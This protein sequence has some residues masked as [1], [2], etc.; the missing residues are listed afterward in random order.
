MRRILLVAALLLAAPAA[1]VLN[2]TGN[3]NTTAPPGTADPGWLN[4]GRLGG[5]NGVYMGYGW[6]L[7]AAHVGTGPGTIVLD[8]DTYSIVVSTRVVI[9]HDGSANADLA[10]MKIDPLPTQLPVLEIASTSPGLDEK[11][12]LIGK[13]RNQG[14]FTTWGNDG[15]EWASP[16]QTRW[17]TNLIG[18]LPDRGPPVRFAEAE[19]TTGNKVTQKAPIL[20]KNGRPQL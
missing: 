9:D 16:G 10:A 8:G 6:I 2:D 19:I 4:V 15:W 7:T 1:A 17:G 12:T 11:V 3:G 14:A 18:G 5:L 13:G 20:R